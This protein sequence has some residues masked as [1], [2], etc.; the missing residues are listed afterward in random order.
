VET[1]EDGAQGSRRRRPCPAWWWWISRCPDG[2]AWRISR[3][4]AIDPEIILVVIT[5]YATID[6]AVEAMKSGAYDFPQALLAPRNC[7]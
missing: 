1:F 6:T 2:A 3:V 5:G 7:G 4:H